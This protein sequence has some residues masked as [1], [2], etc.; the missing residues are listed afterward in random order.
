MLLGTVAILHGVK[1]TI[2]R[3]K[4]PIPDAFCITDGIL[5]EAPL[6]EPLRMVIA[7]IGEIFHV[8]IQG[9]G[10]FGEA[11]RR[12]GLGPAPHIAH[13]HAALGSHFPEGTRLDTNGAVA[14]GINKKRGLKLLPLRSARIKGKDTVDTITVHRDVVGM[15][16]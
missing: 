4:I 1:G 15:V 5:I 16:V 12:F 13:A 2:G 7:G 3:A 10:G 9:P 8:E 11:N 14:R 6:P